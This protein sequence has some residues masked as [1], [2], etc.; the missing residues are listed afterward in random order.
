MKLNKIINAILV[1]AAFLILFISVFRTAAVTPNFS[2]NFSKG[3]TVEGEVIDYPLVYAGRILPG[4]AFWSVKATRDRLWLF[5][6]SNPS[7]KAE[8]NLLFADKRLGAY[9]ELMERGDLENAYVSLIKAEQYL[10]KASDKEV[11]IR[12][13]G[14]DTTDL[15]IRLSNSSLKHQEVINE[16]KT[17][18]P[19]N[20]VA[21]LVL[22]EN[23]TV[24]VYERSKS[25]LLEK[26]LTPPEYPF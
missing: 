2:S 12:N 23:Y 8:L 22:V 15:L 24:E 25:A 13:K 14:V 16:A 9:I 26:G 11:E 5:F 10:K 19:D 3:T 20:A 4:H 18:F 6:T 1:F 17:K 21:D 7:R